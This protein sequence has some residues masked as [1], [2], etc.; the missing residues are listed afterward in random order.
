MMLQA[1]TVC[2]L[3]SQVYVGFQVLIPCALKVYDVTV[4]ESV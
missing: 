2:C 1:R 3:S 4:V